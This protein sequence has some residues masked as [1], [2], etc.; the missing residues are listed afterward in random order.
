MALDTLDTPVIVDRAETDGEPLDVQT[1]LERL[2]DEEADELARL[3]QE[4]GDPR[5]G[6][7][8]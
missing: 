3:F 4:A 2:T 7:R 8:K 1:R 5:N 6:F